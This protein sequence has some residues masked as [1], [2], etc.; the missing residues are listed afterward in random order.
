MKMLK[1]FQLTTGERPLAEP[2]PDALLAAVV[3][4]H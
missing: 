2:L 4:K 3:R 1:M